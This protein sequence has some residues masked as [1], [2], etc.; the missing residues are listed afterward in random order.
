M[1]T[2]ILT[3]ITTSFILSFCAKRPSKNPVPVIEFIDVN[4]LAQV[5]SVSM[6]TRD[7]AVIII[8]YEDGDGDLFTDRS[9][10]DNNFIFTPYTVD[11]TGK[12]RGMVN[13][14]T[15][16][17]VRLTYTIKQPDNGYYKGKSIQGEIYV[18]LREFRESEDI[19]VIKF[20]G[21]MQDMKKHRSNVI[22]SPVYT[23]NF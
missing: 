10:D 16:D 19:K 6:G 23:L 11:G 21:F 3:I 7:T 4:P 1:T 22:S 12:F 20:V 5:T 14:V 9:S 2:R 13:P 17:T 18:P 15:Q 8:H